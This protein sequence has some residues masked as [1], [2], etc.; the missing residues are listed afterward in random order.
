MKTTSPNANLDID[1]DLRA[2]EQLGHDSSFKSLFQVQA[3]LCRLAVPV[4]S[5]LPLGC[6]EGGHAVLAV[7]NSSI[8]PSPAARAPHLG[9][10]TIKGAFKIGSPIDSSSLNGQPYNKVSDRPI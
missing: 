7:D 4:R 3:H 6:A 10:D 2:W 5:P 8:V 9:G 1:V